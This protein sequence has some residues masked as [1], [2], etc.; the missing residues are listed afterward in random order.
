MKI[1]YKRLW[2]LLSIALLSACATYKPQYNTEAISGNFEED[3]IIHSI[4]LIGDAGNSPLGSKSP[5][6]AAFEKSLKQAKKNSTALFL[7]D[8]IYPEGMPSKSEE[9]RAYGEH[10]LNVQTDVVKDFKGDAIFIPGNHDWYSNGLKGL[11][12]Q[13]KYIEDKLGKNTFLP[14]NGCP[15]EKV[16][17][18][19]DIELIIIDSEWFVTDWD[20]HPTINDDCEIK[21]RFKFFEELEGLIKKARGKT[22]VIAIHHP[23][24]SNG[25]HGGEYSFGAHMKP[26][27]ILGTLKNVLRETSGVSPADLQHK[28]Y[29]TLK[30]RLVT[31]AQENDKVVFVSGHDHN[32]QYIEQDNLAQIIS[33]A[34]AKST[35]TRN[36]KDAF[37]SSEGGFAR[38]DIL[39]D[40][41][42]YVRFFSAKDDKVIF[43]TQVFAE[44]KKE[45]VG[46]YPKDV[47]KTVNASVYSEDEV[48]K[49]GFYKTIWG[50]R[51]RKY[52]GVKVNAPTVN[53]DTLFGGLKP[54]RKGGGHQSKSL[55]L[56]NDEGQRYVM[57]AIRKSAVVY[58]QAMAFKDQYI[59][60][61]F[62]GTTTEKLLADFYTGSHPYAP[63]VTGKLSDAVNLFH[64]NPVLYYV[65][66]QNALGQY[67]VS[68]GGE[69]Y[70]IEE[71]VSDSH[72]NLKSFGYTKSIESTDDLMKKLRKDEK[73]SV[74]EASFLRARLFDMAIGDWDRHTDQWRW[75]EF[76][77]KGKVIY[78]PI[79]R[80]R[81][82]AF[83]I[84]GD[85]ALMKFATRVIPP[86][87]LME[88]FD[89]DIRNIKGFNFSPFS[90]DMM[91][92]NQTSKKQW[93]EQVAFIQ[94]NLTDDVIDAA[95]EDFPKEVQTETVAE[96]KRVLKARLKNLPKIANDYFKVLNKNVLV[97]GTD[98]DDLFE[99]ERM[100]NGNTKVS[101]YRIKKG[102]KGTLF[103]EK[104]FNKNIT[105]EVWIYGLD[106]EDVFKVFGEGNDL[107]KIRLVGGQN[108]DV[109]TIENGKKVKFYDYKS[110][111]S[112]ITT[113]KGS[114]KLTDDYE[115]NIYD[116]S[117]P[118]NNTNQFVPTIG[119]NPDDGFKIGFVNTYTGYGFERNP[120]TSQHTISSAYYFATNGFELGYNGEFAN[121]IG[122]WNL[123]LDARFTSPNYAIN[124]FGYGNS[125]P[126]PEAD[127][128]DGLDVDL[129]YNRV[130]LQTLRFSP[131]LIWRGDLGASFKVG[132]KYESV[133]IEE[134][135]GRFINQF[136]NNNIDDVENDFVGAEVSYAYQNHDN[137]AFPTMGMR[138]SLSAG[139]ISKLKASEG[140]AYIIPELSFDYK[141]IHSGQLVLATKSRGHFNLGDDFEF[142]QAANIGANSGLRGYRNERFTGK[143]AFVQ[144]SDLRLNLRKFKTGLLPLN[145]GIYGGFDIGKVWVDDDMVLNPAHN[146]NDWNTSIGGGIFAN[147][148]QITTLNVS[149]FN[150]DDGLRFAFK[151]GFGF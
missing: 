151:V 30:K 35:A 3:D 68:F 146:S 73:Y 117:K 28:R 29:H 72:K 148:A 88:G 95:L 36:V 147:L 26:L 34:G 5:A 107:I 131:A 86:L 105:K 150:S 142:Y 15:I 80:D 41:S 113:N 12:R 40:G 39:N 133:E 54:F 104:T 97:K 66:K 143:S 8:N 51:Y 21:T 75:A 114:K 99:I 134:T 91:L 127:E 126:N 52:Y 145:I 77:E 79:P 74:D 87:K 47:P 85:G 32:L 43:Q 48:S 112:E 101:G 46:S 2:A 111:K 141:L 138:F 110:K 118:K 120:F 27:P 90:L 81:D 1:H 115:T 33:G 84:M 62:E 10:Q 23:M 53:L 135:Q 98:K 121:V 89:E 139:Y 49:S 45:H 9:G 140:F 82:Q 136:A 124:F 129:D 31:L 19:D 103:F 22:T 137:E 128:N 123:A 14:E 55:H 6:L 63:F 64:T 76:K 20:K 132:L 149:A 100:P 57:R 4:Y 102:E 60:G 58:L 83:S 59:E 78:K 42:S 69:L 116:Y 119:A 94:D 70:M 7:G 11:K 25:P 16:E 92:L 130:K 61:Q 50:E 17:I 38:L 93:E 24:Y 96:I 109:Y 37:S 44:D 13:E 144:T 67:N 125:T 108:K 122:S 18:A 65:P 106:D 56:I 71:H